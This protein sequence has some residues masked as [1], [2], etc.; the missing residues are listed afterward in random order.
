LSHFRNTLPDFVERLAMQI[1]AEPLAEGLLKIVLTGRM[2]IEGTQAIDL[3]LAGHTA[4]PNASF[5]VD[6]SEVT[7]LASIGIR[8]LLSVA[9]AVR[10]RGGRLA[11]LGPVEN[12]DRTLRTAGIDTLIPICADLESA[13]AAVSGG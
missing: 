1:A 10:G 4:T 6:L 8:S 12:V 9:K 11:L 3:K 7:F 2:D 13:R 5:V